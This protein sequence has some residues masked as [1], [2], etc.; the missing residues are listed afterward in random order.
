M[1]KIPKVE[2]EFKV[3]PA[4]KKQAEVAKSVFT[5]VGPDLDAYQAGGG[6]I[7]RSGG[8]LT[9]VPGAT[10]AISPEGNKLVSR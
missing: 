8:A 5:T 3:K 6:C 1:A 2:V 10:L 9:F 7:V 4:A